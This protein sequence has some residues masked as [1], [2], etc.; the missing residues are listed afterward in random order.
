MYCG[1]IRLEYHTTVT[2]TTQTHT[3]RHRK[4]R[5]NTHKLEHVPVEHIVVGEALSVEEVSE[6]L[7]QVRVVRLVVEAQR[8]AEVEVRGE[9][10]C[11]KKGDT[12][13]NGEVQNAHKGG[14]CS[15]QHQSA[16]LIGVS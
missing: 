2:K 8:A 13:W 1:S 9:L 16:S 10:R 15:I 7:S 5:Q 3:H 12:E 14:Q 4:S 11:R 6:Q